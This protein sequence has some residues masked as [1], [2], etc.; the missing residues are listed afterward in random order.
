MSKR[1]ECDGSM[2]RY[3]L[4]FLWCCYAIAWGINQYDNHRSS[5]S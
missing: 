3:T 1:S 4:R 5:K 2:T